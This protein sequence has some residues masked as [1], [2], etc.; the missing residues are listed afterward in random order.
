MARRTSLNVPRMIAVMT[1][2]VLVGFPLVGY[3]WDTLNELLGT[4]VHLRRIALS[5][6]LI[7]VFA[8]IL[9]LLSRT[10]LG[11]EGERLEGRRSTAARSSHDH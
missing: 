3:I 1:V 9:V 5:L 7:I 4:E 2:F 10:V 6:L 11:W 8:G